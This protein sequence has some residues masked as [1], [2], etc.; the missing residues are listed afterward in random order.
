MILETVGFSFIAMPLLSRSLLRVVIFAVVQGA[1]Q[2][3]RFMQPL[4][5]LL[6]LYLLRVVEIAHQSSDEDAGVE[7][8]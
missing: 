1:M 4:L 6:N 3:V 2:M 7:R 5:P 8:C